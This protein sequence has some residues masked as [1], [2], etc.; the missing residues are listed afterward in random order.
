MG[1]CA[2]GHFDFDF[3]QLVHRFLAARLMDISRSEIPNPTLRNI[4]YKTHTDPDVWM[5]I[6]VGPP[7]F[8]KSGIPSK[9]NTASKSS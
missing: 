6:S 9:G 4:I 2:L 7:E 5:P 8:M 1:S 3:N